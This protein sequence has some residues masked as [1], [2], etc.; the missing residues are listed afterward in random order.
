[1]PTC[2]TEREKKKR[3]VKMYYRQDF[4]EEEFEKLLIK[5]FPEQNC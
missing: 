5:F 3:I 1:M 2:V 4:S